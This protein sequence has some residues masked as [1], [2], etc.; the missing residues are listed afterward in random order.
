[1]STKRILGITAF[2]VIFIIIII[3]VILLVSDL[4]PEGGTLTLPERSE[5]PEGPIEPN[6]DAP[7]RVEVTRETVQAVISTLTR[8]D[9][10]TR[11]LIVESFWDSGQAV[12]YI[13]VAV[14]ADVTSLKVEPPVGDEKRII[15]TSEALYIWYG[16]ETAPFIG[17][18]GSD[19]DGYRTADEY[20]MLTSY[21]SILDFNLYDIID[22]GYTEYEGEDCIYISYRTVELG[23]T[24]TCYIS[25][26]L[27]LITCAEEFDETGDLIY[28]VK[29]GEC[30]IGET[31][32]KM[33]TLPDGALLWTIS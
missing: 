26:R 17:A 6:P 3:V 20:Q 29:A 9:T 14:N 28:R 5:S 18:P 21:E 10:Y 24:M 8:P 22:A 32:P 4:S 31:D 23:N 25:I 19:G 15:V 7:N 1:M 33:F 12:F 30:L 11:R 27:G 13:D 2:G 16:S